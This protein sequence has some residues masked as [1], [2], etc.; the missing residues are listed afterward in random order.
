MNARE[1]VVILARMFDNRIKDH[2]PKAEAFLIM[3]VDKAGTGESQESCECCIKKFIDE[4]MHYNS[5]CTSI[6][7]IEIDDI[8]LKDIIR[9]IVE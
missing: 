2:Y 6:G 7:C 1:A 9:L 4:V 5:K 3:L 8:D